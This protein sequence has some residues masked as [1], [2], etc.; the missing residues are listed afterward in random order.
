M[1]KQP[2]LWMLSLRMPL[3]NF[4]IYEELYAIDPQILQTVPDSC[5]IQKPSAHAFIPQVC[6]PCY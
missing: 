6:K 3:A 2:I 1:H 5:S 4:L